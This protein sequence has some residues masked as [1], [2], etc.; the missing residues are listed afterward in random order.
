M[1]P[2]PPLRLLVDRFHLMIFDLL[3]FCIMDLWANNH[4]AS[5][6]VTFLVSYLIC[7]MRDL[8]GNMSVA[9]NTLVDERFLI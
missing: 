9:K 4:V 8:L 7:W 2:P 6:L 1:L 5:A 3:T